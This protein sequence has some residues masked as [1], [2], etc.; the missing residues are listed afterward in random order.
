[1][2]RAKE[3][4]AAVAIV[5]AVIVFVLVVALGF[6][7]WKNLSS[8]NTK[9]NT[10]TSSTSNSKGTSQKSSDIVDLGND[11]NKY[12]DY[13]QGLEFDYPKNVQGPTSCSYMNTVHGTNGQDIPASQS[14][15][16]IAA[17]NS[18]TT[19]LKG[20][21]RYV[22]ASKEVGVL[23]DRIK[24]GDYVLAQACDMTPTTFDLVDFKNTDG[25]D[26]F[27]DSVTLEFDVSSTKSQADILNYIKK[28]T[29][30]NDVSI[31]KMGDLQDGRQD[32]SYVY[33]QNGQYAGG[34]YKLW[35]YPAL[36]KLVYVALG[37]GVHLI[38][39]DELGKTYDQQVVDSFQFST[40]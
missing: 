21:G 34:A 29:G 39:N 6:L 1:M 3:I 38:S 23:S 10:T 18:P 12:I 40:N 8:K 9:I 31:D 28:I 14:Y 2:N 16:Q 25:A 4:G 5:V 33:T 17:G 11:L 37:Q 7:F 30:T 35:Y 13:Q 19:I 20:D 24:S 36:Q 22:I 15:Y 27:V 32:V 26:K